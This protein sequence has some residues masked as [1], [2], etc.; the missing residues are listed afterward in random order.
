MLFDFKRNLLAGQL[1]DMVESRKH[2]SWSPE[3]SA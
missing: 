2:P 3:E 1:E